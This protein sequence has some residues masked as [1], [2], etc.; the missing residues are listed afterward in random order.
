MN[1]VDMLNFIIGLI[2]TLVRFVPLGFY[3]FTYFSS[4][5]YKDLRSAILLIGLIINDLL[6]YL[7][8]KYAKIKMKA[9]CA[10]FGKEGSNTEL[11]FLPNAHT[12]IVTFVASFYFSDMY[13]K[14]KLDP[15]PFVFLLVL[16]FVTIW[17]RI[18]IGCKEFKELSYNILFG[19]IFGVI[20]YYLVQKYYANADKGILEK[21]T[22][23]L[24]YNN[25]RCDEIKDGVVIIKEGGGDA[26]DETT[27][28]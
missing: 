6:G 16:V 8:K 12:Q 9:P 17:S 11:G 3:F 25:Y 27:E 15:I 19:I 20:Y 24:G 10:I 21:E 13:F 5:I 18:T 23:E 1:F 26:D 14:E 4:T 2:H 22:C 7:I 28:E